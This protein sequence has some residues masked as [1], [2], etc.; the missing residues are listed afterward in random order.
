M[1]TISFNR[2]EIMDMAI[3]V[4]EFIPSLKDEKTG[5]RWFLTVDEILEKIQKSLKGYKDKGLIKDYRNR[6]R[7]YLNL[8]LIK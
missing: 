6:V 5:E 4:K 1:V 8:E 2:N 7:K 3:I